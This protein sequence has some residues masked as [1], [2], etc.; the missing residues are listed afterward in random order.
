V[1]RRRTCARGTGTAEL[2]FEDCRLLKE[3]VLGKEGDGF[4][5]AMM[6]LN[7]SRI[8]VAAGGIGL[9]QEQLRKG[10]DDPQGASCSA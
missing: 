9:A 7:E 10:D 4:L 1:G 3:D 2:V 5:I 6:I 8:G